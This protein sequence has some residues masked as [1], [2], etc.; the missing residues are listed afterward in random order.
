MGVLDSNGCVQKSLTV[1]QNAY[2]YVRTIHSNSENTRNIYVQNPLSSQNWTT[3]FQYGGYVEFQKTYLIGAG[4]STLVL[5]TYE[6]GPLW[7]TSASTLAGQIITKRDTLAFFPESGKTYNFSGKN[8][9]GFAYHGYEDN[10]TPG[11]TFTDAIYA[12]SFVAE[13]GGDGSVDKF[14]SAH[15][16]GHGIMHMNVLD[17]GSGPDSYW[18]IDFEPM[19]NCSHYDPNEG[20]TANIHCIQSN[21]Y[22]RS[23]EFEGFADFFSAA[24]WNP[25]PNAQTIAPYYKEIR[26]PPP[27]PDSILDEPPA[28]RPYDGLFAGM[29][30]S[31]SPPRFLE[32]YC[33]G[34]LADRGTE[35]DW[36][37]FYWRLWTGVYG[38]PISIERFLDVWHTWVTDPEY[39]EHWYW[40]HIDIAAQSV[41]NSAEYNAFVT[42]AQD[43][44]I[45]H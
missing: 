15:E 1:N 38:A 7:E 10:V 9:Q 26:Y 13:G 6:V 22:I 40:R 20:W 44:G 14:K 11:G 25:T 24:L 17:A 30:Q 21:E 8:G 28:F 3:S 43:C 32:T 16:V 29:T 34:N 23:A 39:D 18:G 41:L 12:V 45:D 5:P 4:S 36:L 37:V 2:L 19:C 33:S 42:A 27:P 31:Y 35:W